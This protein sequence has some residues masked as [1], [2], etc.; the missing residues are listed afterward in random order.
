MQIEGKKDLI[1]YAVS[2]GE[3]LRALE[4]RENGLTEAEAAKRLAEFG[5]NELKQGKKKGAVILFF[6]QFKN[7][8]T[9]IL[10]AAAIISGLSQ[11]P[12]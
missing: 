3:A 1:P 7:A 10:M 6:E 8:M 12:R 11:R 2:G 4:A 5:R 9:L